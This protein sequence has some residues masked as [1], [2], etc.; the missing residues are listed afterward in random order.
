M[1]TTTYG[2]KCDPF[3]AWYQLRDDPTYCWSKSCHTTGESLYY[4]CYDI[5]IDIDR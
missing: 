4:E 1:K 5:Y 3:E 2:G